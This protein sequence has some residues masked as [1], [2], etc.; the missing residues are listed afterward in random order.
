M[1]VIEGG[2]VSAIEAGTPQ[3]S[4]ISPLLANVALNVLDDVWATGGRRMGVLV[5]YADDLVVLCATR[6]QA[7]QARELA[8]TTLEGLALRFIPTR[9]GSPTS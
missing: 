8:A 4:P 2:I 3:G 5:R 9:P 1:G 6:K 7:E